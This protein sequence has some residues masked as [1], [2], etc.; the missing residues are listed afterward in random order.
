MVSV[1]LTAAEHADIAIILDRR[2]DLHPNPGALG[3]GFCDLLMRD[4]DEVGI[5][6]YAD[7]SSLN[8]R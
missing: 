8:S 4:L 2:L 5:V 7:D 6:Q 1:W 3:K